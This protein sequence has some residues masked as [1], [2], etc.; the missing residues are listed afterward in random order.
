VSASDDGRILVYANSERDAFGFVDIADPAAPKSAGEI[1][2]GG[3]PTS[4]TVVDGQAL[5]VVSTSKDKKIAALQ[6]R[7][8]ALVV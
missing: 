7:T 4:V 5:V 2:V 1:S 8:R 3:E 6:Q